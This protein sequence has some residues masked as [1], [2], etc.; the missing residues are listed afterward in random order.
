MELLSIFA[1]AVGLA[2]DAF[3]AAICKGLQLREPEFS[4]TFSVGLCFGLFQGLMP[5]FGYLLAS[6]FAEDIRAIDHWVAFFLLGI[7][8]AHMIRESFDKTCDFT[9]GFDI[10]SLLLI[11]L[12]TSIDAMAIGIS[13]AFLKVNIVSSSIIIGLTTFV[14][15]MIGMSIGNI[16]G[17][18]YKS[19]AERVGGLILIAMGIK[20]LLEHTLFA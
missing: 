18:K 9:T 4:K 6:A 15:A 13:F 10:K 7:I 5:V 2:M 1:I 16:F 19:A 11:G 3:A 17:I 20:I 8:G 12:A 14:I